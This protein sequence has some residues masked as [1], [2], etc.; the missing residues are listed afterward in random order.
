[1][2]YALLLYASEVEWQR[3]SDAELS[4]FL[5]DREALATDLERRGRF[6]SSHALEHTASA[7]TVRV[8]GGRV[9]V[10]DG[11]FAETKEQ[12]L[13]LYL[14]EAEDLD[15]AMAIAERAPDARVGSV[16][17]RPVRESV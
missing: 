13:G 5:R 11:P 9:L 2:R 8:R 7:T 17:I 10:T 16:E 3:R 12:L 14:V 4:A 15:E 6:R 1:M